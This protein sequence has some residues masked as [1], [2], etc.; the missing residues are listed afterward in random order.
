MSEN[1]KKLSGGAGRPTVGLGILSWKGHFT[2]RKTLDSYRVSGLFNLFDRNLIYFNDLCEADKKIAEEYGLEY[3]GGPN[4]GIAAGTENLA[5]GLCTDYVLLLQNDCPVAEGPDSI[6]S[7]MEYAIHLLESGRVNQMRMRHRW[8]AGEG[9]D[10]HK[11]LRY[12]GVQKLDP[13]FNFNETGVS[14]AELADSSLKR[15]RRLLRPEKAGKLSGM[16]VYL[17]KNPHERFPAV[18]R[19]E[20]PVYIVDSSALTFTEQSFLIGRDFFLNV[21]MQYV[22]THPSPRTI[23]GFQVPERCLNCRWWKKQHFKIGIG[24]GIFTHNRFDGSFRNPALGRKLS[25]E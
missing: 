13:Q 20:G 2:L 12:F 24:A 1:T 16:C 25:S 14:S 21:L 3:T 8:H 17:E 22:N 11:F 18:I 5:R 6:R 10:L 4:V 15:L 7:Q 19:K 9:F 23:R